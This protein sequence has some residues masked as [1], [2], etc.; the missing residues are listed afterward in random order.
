M[1]SNVFK[2]LP[3]FCALLLTLAIVLSFSAAFA[4]EGTSILITFTG[5]CTLGSDEWLKEQPASFDAFIQ[6]NGYSYPFEKLLDIFENDDLTVINL[7]N[8]F[9]DQKNNRANKNYTF[10]GPSAFANIL[11]QGSVELAFVANNHIMDY[12]YTGMQSTINSLTSRNI[13]WFGTNYSVNQTYVYEK[14][15]IRVGFVGSYYSYWGSNF[16]KMNQAFQQLKEA[17]CHVIVGIIH[18]GVEYAA[19]RHFRQEDMA[20]WMVKNGANVVI[21][22]HPHV[23]QGV[24]II[25]DVSVVYSLGNC[26]FGGNISLDIFR[27]PGVRADKA[28]LA[29]VEFRFDSDKKYLG[30]QLNI[31]PISPSG[32]TNYNNYQP[33]LLQGEEALATLKLVQDDTSFK[34][35]PFVEGK[36]SMQPFLPAS[37]FQQEADSLP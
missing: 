2:F 6:K 19:N 32:T 22:H 23:P 33:V 9:S 29:Q 11:L 13:G 25:G 28:L 35:A 34:L 16:P 15:G 31:I 10:R 3:R 37:S 30:H 8:V 17:G 26:S 24:D 27:R 1:F 12:G 14:N 18:D 4:D 5:D 7:E 36:G 20:K 21:G